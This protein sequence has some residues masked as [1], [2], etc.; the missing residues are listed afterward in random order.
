VEGSEPGVHGDG[1]RAAA[2]GV[3]LVVSIAR[4][5]EVIYHRGRLQFRQPRQGPR[6]RSLPR[7]HPTLNL[8]SMNGMLYF[9]RSEEVLS[10]NFILSY[11]KLSNTLFLI[12]RN[13]KYIQL[14]HALLVSSGVAES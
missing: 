4:T 7:S 5:C 14:L 11:T 6:H 2:R 3:Q 8:E 13:T 12:G 1:P 10:T 9:L